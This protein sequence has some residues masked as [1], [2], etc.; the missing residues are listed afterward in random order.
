MISRS[1]HGPLQLHECA[2]PAAALAADHCRWS[3]ASRQERR[4]G[5]LLALEVPQAA[6]ATPGS[7]LRLI[8]PGRFKKPRKFPHGKAAHAI[9]T[10]L[11]NPSVQMEGICAALLTSPPKKTELI[12]GKGLYCPR[13]SNGPF[14]HKT[15]HQETPEPC[16]KTHKLQSAAF[17]LPP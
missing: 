2:P 14:H 5:T 16:T 6:A 11:R 3:S 1:I 13:D 8:I 9:V 12:Q 7:G 4:A 15:S 10:R 17:A